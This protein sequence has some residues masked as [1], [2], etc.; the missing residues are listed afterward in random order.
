M[1]TSIYAFDR[2][3]EGAIGALG[4]P[5]VGWIAEHGFGMSM[6]DVYA[7]R[8]KSLSDAKALSDALLVMLIYPW[9]VCLGF[10]FFLHV[11]YK[12]DRIKARAGQSYEALIE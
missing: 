5:A 8:G 12:K 11:Y 2:S 4:T 10:Y 6:E 7:K 1:R 3:F 9:M